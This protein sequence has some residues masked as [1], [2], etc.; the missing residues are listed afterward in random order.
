MYLRYAKQFTG[1]FLN[2]QFVT[3]DKSESK[4][5]GKNQE[6]SVKTSNVSVIGRDSKT[7]VLT[8]MKKTKSITKVRR[9][10]STCAL[11]VIV[12]G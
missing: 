1:L 11:L 7:N 9:K 2:E 10:T 12:G 6:A 3:L 8:N 4:W 5:M